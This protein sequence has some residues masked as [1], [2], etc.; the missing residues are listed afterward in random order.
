MEVASG[1]R[2]TW[3]DPRNEAPGWGR[4][5]NRAAT[6]LAFVFHDHEKAVAVAQ[7]VSLVHSPSSLHHVIRWQTQGQ[8]GQEGCPVHRHGR[9]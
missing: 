8:Q 4:S 6:Q 7:V 1:E 3:N 2:L 9:R 5:L